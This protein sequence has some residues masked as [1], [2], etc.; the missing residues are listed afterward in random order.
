[1]CTKDV[2][3]GLFAENAVGWHAMPVVVYQYSAQ[4]TAKANAYL[5]V[6]AAPIQSLRPP[7]C[8]LCLVSIEG[9]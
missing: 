9:V 5:C 4:R 1:M 2:T 7:V 3:Q 6:G 8:D